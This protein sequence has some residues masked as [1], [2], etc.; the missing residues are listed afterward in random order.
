[1][2]R[3]HKPKGL[4]PSNF[5][6]AWLRRCTGLS[7]AQRLT[8]YISFIFYA[9]APTQAD[10]IYRCGEAYSTSNQC[11]NTTATEVKPTSTLHTTGQDKNYTTNSD[12]REAQSLEKQRLQAER[13]AAQSAPIRLSTPPPSLASTTSN[14]PLTNGKKHNGKQIR[15]PNSPYFTAVDPKAEPKKKSTAKAVP[16]SSTP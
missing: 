3:R 6:W 8:V 9:I 7:H 12:M 1:M 14:E 4:S 13:Q 16:A 11:G 10:T 2:L 15:K 5:L